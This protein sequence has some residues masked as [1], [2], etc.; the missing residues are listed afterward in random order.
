MPVS[1]QEFRQL[2]LEDPDGHWELYCGLPRQKPG[3]TL[4]H[5]HVMTELF[6]ILWQQLDRTQ[7]DL[8]ANAGHVQH[9]PQHYFIPDVFVI[10]VALQA[11]LRGTRAL[12]SCTAALPLVVEI[13]SPSTGTLR[14]APEALGVPAARRPGALAPA[15][16]PPGGAN[17]MAAT[18]S[19]TTKVALSSPSRCR[20]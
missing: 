16:S 3:M 14:C 10:P 18:R 5:N 19:P 7:F 1:E 17:R 13:W 9:T 11:P 4:E 6:G 8:R 2:V 20:A 15:P 12:E